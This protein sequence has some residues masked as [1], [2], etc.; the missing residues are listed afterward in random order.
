MWSLKVL[1][2]IATLPSRHL[3][4]SP[5]P[6]RNRNFW[7]CS[8]WPYLCGPFPDSQQL[9]PCASSTDATL[10]PSR[11]LSLAWPG[12]SCLRLECLSSC[13]FSCCSSGAWPPRPPLPAQSP[14]ERPVHFHPSTSWNL[15]FSYSRV[16]LIA[17]SSSHWMSVLVFYFP[18]WAQ[19]LR[20][21]LTFSRFW[22]NASWFSWMNEAIS[23]SPRNV[24]CR[25]MMRRL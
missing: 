16:Y 17:T 15:P 3:P 11:L 23:L 19:H 9:V 6:P 20:R 4:C 12:L 21:Y 5:F 2:F 24:Q 25:G 22:I 1:I 10:A 7:P 18:Q 14:S 13:C 8:M